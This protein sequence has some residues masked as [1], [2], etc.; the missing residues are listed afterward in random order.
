MSNVVV[1][2]PNAD[3]AAGLREIA[4]TIERDGM[5]DCC[6]TVII[7]G[8]I[9]HVGTLDDTEAAIRAVFDMNVGL[10]KLM[11]AA[12]RVQCLDDD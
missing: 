2:R 8:D 4:D 7:E 1:L 6:A 3:I 10:S 12:H 5:Q 9:Y 11:L